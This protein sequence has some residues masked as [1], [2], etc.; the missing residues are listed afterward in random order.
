MFDKTIMRTSIIK[1]ILATVIA[2]TLPLILV[3]CS[4]K[5]EKLILLGREKLL[6]ILAMLID[7]K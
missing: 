1:G 2:T 6:K 4:P 5:L 7:G 3:G